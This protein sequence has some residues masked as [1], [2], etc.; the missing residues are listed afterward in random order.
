[1]KITLN[2]QSTWSKEDSV[3]AVRATVTMVY[4]FKLDSDIIEVLQGHID[5]NAFK[6]I[7]SVMRLAE[8]IAD[9]DTVVDVIQALELTNIADKDLKALDLKIEEV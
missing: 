7:D 1:M 3:P 6:G 5:R 4:E 2:G 8:V 9:T